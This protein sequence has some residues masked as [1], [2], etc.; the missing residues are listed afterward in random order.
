MKF[1]LILFILIPSAFAIEAVVTVLETPM[2]SEPRYDAKV[3]QYLRKGD[4]VKLH[5]SLNKNEDYDHLAPSVEKFK[6]IDEKIRNSDEWNQDPLFR[7]QMED[8]SIEDTFISALDRQGHKIYLIRDHLYI[9]FENGK[10][11]TQGIL[12]QDP[13]DYRLQ[14]PLPKKYPLLEPRGYRGQFIL[15]LTQPYQESY[16]YSQSFKAKGYTI[17]IDL[18]ISFLRQEPSDIQNRLYFGVTFNM[19]YHKNEFLFFDGRTSTESTI[20][21]GLGPIITYETYKEKFNRLNIFVSININLFNQMV[22]KQQDQNISESKIF[23][24]YNLAPRLGMQYFRKA[25]FEDIDF[26]AGT[27][28]EI[29]PATTF[30]SKN[31]SSQSSWWRSSSNDKFYSRTTFSLAGH[32]GVQAAY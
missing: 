3:V 30:R 18:N 29:E 16:D 4:I 10:E 26:V 22:I 2:L 1:F 21:F 23:R 7:G 32:L 19:R 20:K 17:P 15:G 25:I 14:E 27:Y 28:I 11:L 8:V 5:P 24:T 31:S 13:T 9:Y 12:T 6:I